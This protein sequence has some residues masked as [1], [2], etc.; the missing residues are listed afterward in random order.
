VYVG[1]RNLNAIALQ[2]LEWG[3][4]IAGREREG[5]EKR[6]KGTDGGK[7]KKERWMDEEKVKEGFS[8]KSSSTC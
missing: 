7:T 6:R 2:N 4:C 8:C 3:V 1:T 5:E